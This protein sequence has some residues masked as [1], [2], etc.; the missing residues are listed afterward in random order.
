M[1]HNAEDVVSVAA[2]VNVLVCIENLSWQGD[3]SNVTH[4][5]WPMT[6]SS[7]SLSSFLAWILARTNWTYSKNQEASCLAFISPRTLMRSFPRAISSLIT[8]F[9][10]AKAFFFDSNIS[11]DVLCMV[12]THFV[13][14]FKS[15]P[16]RRST[17]NLR[18]LRVP[19]FE[20]VGNR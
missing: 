15:F 2:N 5:T 4:D 10:S 13:T 19:I 7:D 3:N 14:T 8:S 1:R 17:M 18:N 16:G 9:P 12:S 20:R 11:K 6:S